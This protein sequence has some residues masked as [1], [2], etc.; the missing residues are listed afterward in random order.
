M[1]VIRKAFPP[2]VISESVIRKVLKTC[3]DFKREGKFDEPWHV[4]VS[5][6]PWNT[7]FPILLPRGFKLIMS[8]M[9]ILV[10][11]ALQSFRFGYLL[12]LHSMLNG[13]LLVGGGGIH[14]LI[15][16]VCSIF[17]TVG[18]YRWCVY[19]FYLLRG[20]KSFASMCEYTAPMYMP[21]SATVLYTLT[22]TAGYENGWWVLRGDF[23]LPTSEELRSLISPEQVCSYQSMLASEHRLKV[24]TNATTTT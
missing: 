13:F 15:M 14:M 22:Y 8:E 18:F 12:L 17:M 7:L 19:F 11:I 1:D 5:C 10:P 9:S 23:R 24:S 4:S 16:R 2:S 6:G 20:W 3:A 21:G